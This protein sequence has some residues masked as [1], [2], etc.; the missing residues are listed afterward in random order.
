M[1]Y[2]WP[3]N[4]R[5]LENAIEH[6]FVTRRIDTIELEDLP[7][8]MRT[9]SQRAIECRDRGT[10]VPPS[11]ASKPLTKDTLLQALKACSGNQ[12]ETACR[13]GI[14]RTTVWRKMKHWEI[15][16]PVGN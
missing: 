1:D 5:E 6:A 10:E 11:K 14:D 12:S 8:E 15:Q 16:P 9:A 13:L 3:G 2:C 4:V 7:F